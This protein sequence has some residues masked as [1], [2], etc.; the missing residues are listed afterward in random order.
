MESGLT[1]A[2]SF[3]LFATHSIRDASRGGEYDV[4]VLLLCHQGSTVH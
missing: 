1:K 4:M 3:T 2:V